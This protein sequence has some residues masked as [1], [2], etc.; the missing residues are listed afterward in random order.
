[1]GKQKYFYQPEINDEGNIVG[2]ETEHIWSFEVWRKKKNLLR[3][4]P[5]CTPLKYDEDGIEDPAFMD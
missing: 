2:H 3:D 5:N 4:Y 1:M